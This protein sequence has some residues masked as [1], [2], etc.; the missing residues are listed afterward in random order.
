LAELFNAARALAGAAALARVGRG[1]FDFATIFLVFD[2]TL[3]MTDNYPEEQE[4]L[5]ALHHV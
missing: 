5:A 4:G 2:A 1:G 3:A